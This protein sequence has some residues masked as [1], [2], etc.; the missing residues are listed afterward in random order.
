MEYFLTQQAYRKDPPV[1]SQIDNQ[2]RLNGWGE[3]NKKL[4][5]LVQ[6]RWKVKRGLG[7]EMETPVVATVSRR[8]LSRLKMTKDYYEKPQMMRDILRFTR[9]QLWTNLEIREKIWEGETFVGRG[10]VTTAF[11]PATTIVVN[12]HHTSA[13]LWTKSEANGHLA[14]ARK[15]GDTLGNYVLFASSGPE[16][17]NATDPYCRCHPGEST[18][19][20]KIQ[21]HVAFF[22]CANKNNG[23]L[24]RIANN[25]NCILFLFF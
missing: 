18:N 14:A 15:K 7:N 3:S 17:Y 1:L 21:I 4:A 9:S 16:V 2:A 5:D 8:D 10:V 6:K 13:E 25:N 20:S 19:Y 12:Y 22:F 23:T 11:V 24:F